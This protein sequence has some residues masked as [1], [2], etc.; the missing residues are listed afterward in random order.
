MKKASSIAIDLCAVCACVFVFWFLLAAAGVFKPDTPEV[1]LPDVSTV[2]V[3]DTSALDGWCGSPAGSVRMVGAWFYE[4]GV[5]EDEQ[6]NLWGWDGDLDENGFYLLWI[7]DMGD[8]L[9]Q[10]D[11]IVKL[12]QE[13]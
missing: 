10:N 6:G 3:F 8:S 4:D 12:W 7:D 5:L 2:E 13:I 1:V 9:V 11:E